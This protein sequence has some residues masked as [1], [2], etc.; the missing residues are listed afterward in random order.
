[1]P[2]WQ[3]PQAWTLMFV[4]HAF[5][6]AAARLAGCCGRI[7]GFWLSWQVRQLMTPLTSGK[8]V[9]MLLTPPNGAFCG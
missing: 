6:S 2:L 1:M 5:L 9:P 4:I 3:E 8:P 7:F